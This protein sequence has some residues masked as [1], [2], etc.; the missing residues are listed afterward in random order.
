MSLAIDLAPDQSEKIIYAELLSAGIPPAL[1]VL[2]TA[3]SGHET[4]GW[5]SHVYKTDNN[6]F[7]YGYTGT[8]YKQ[9]PSVEAS[10]DDLADY[11]AR[12]ENEG[13]FP[14][15]G[16]ITDPG[17]YA[18]LLKSAGYYTDSES[19]YQAGIMNYINNALSAAVE[20]VAANPIPSGIVA[21]FII[22][23]IAF[24][25]SRRK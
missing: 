9:Y 23:A 11:L 18:M 7:G 5:T 10:A 6:A 14:A 8:S 22:F 15:L 1:A 20:I 13:S 19:N 17:Q 2:A 16:T 4:G 25:F 12:R 3:Q 21:V 24:I